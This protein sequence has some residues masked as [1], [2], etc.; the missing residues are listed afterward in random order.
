MKIKVCFTGF[1]VLFFLLVPF[2]HPDAAT[3][4]YSTYSWDEAGGLTATVSDANDKINISGTRVSKGVWQTGSLNYQAGATTSRKLPSP[5]TLELDLIAAGSGGSYG[6]GTGYKAFVQFWNDKENFIAFGLIHDPGVAPS[7][8][9]VMVEGAAHGKPIGGYWGANM[10]TL[11]GAAHQFTITWEKDH[12]VWTID[13]LDKYK[14]SYT[15]QM[16]N[17]SMSIMG[18]AREPGDSVSAE[19]RNIYLSTVPAAA[20]SVP[21]EDPRGVISGYVDYDFA[22]SNTGAAVYMNIHDASGTALAYGFQADV[23]DVNSAGLPYL[24]YNKTNLGTSNFTHAYGSIQGV[25]NVPQYWKLA[26]YE[27]AGKAVF[28]VDGTPI[29]QTSITFTDRLFFQVEING[30][31]NGDTIS[32]N[33]SNVSIG[34]TWSDGT[35]VTPN[36]QWNDSFDFWG[37]DAEQIA[38]DASGADFI[39]KGTVTGLPAGADWDNI[40]TTYGYSGRPV[41]AIAMIAEWWYGR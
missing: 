21:T 23:N 11:T 7:G 12:I 24:H 39:F 27:Q 8:V 5:G 22:S 30:A 19:F 16:D 36:G 34:G 4:S 15:I 20:V 31:R 35:A 1:L 14:M 9:T 29:S 6:S 40:E 10:P 2:D 3:T 32:A 18:A 28:F 37:L 13:N 38:G 17:P 26:Y 33:F 25:E 41:A